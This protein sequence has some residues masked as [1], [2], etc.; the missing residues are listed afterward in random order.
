MCGRIYVADRFLMKI[1]APGV[2]LTLHVHYRYDQ[3]RTSVNPVN[4]PKWETIGAAAAGSCRE[5]CPCRWIVNYAINCMGYFSGEFEAE[6]F[7]LFV[8][9][10]DS[11]EQL[12]FGGIKENNAGYFF[13]ELI[14]SN[15]DA[16]GELPISPRS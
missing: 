14:F 13:H 8:I 4:D 7:A 2:G 16:A 15:T 5:S 3:D 1:V 12:S 11:V 10:S 6:S 9:P